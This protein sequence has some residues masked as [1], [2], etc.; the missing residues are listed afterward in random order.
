ME[1]M[2]GR[3]PSPWRRVGLWVGVLVVG[4]L[5]VQVVLTVTFTAVS[6]LRSESAAWQE[7]QPDTV[8]YDYPGY[9]LAVVERH[10]VDYFVLPYPDVRTEIWIG[11]GDQPSYGHVVE[12][13][14]GRDLEGVTTE[15][16]SAGVTFLEASGRV[17]FVP[18]DLFTGG[19]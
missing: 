6:V 7:C 14:V 3:K 18:A 13:E 15:W 5:V 8:E 19:R 11:R 9:C 12:L 10:H 16:T 1:A 17:L 2:A 4:W